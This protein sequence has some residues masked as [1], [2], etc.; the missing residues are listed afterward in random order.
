[1]DLT[2]S[3]RETAVEPPG[4]PPLPRAEPRDLPD[5]PFAGLDGDDA[6]TFDITAHL[7]AGQPMT[8]ELD[9][10][11]RL[12]ESKRADR[13]MP[14]RRDFAFEDLGPW[15]GHLILVDVL[16][17]GRD[18]AFRIFGTRIAEFLGQDLT[19]KRL[20]MLSP[21]VQRA[22]GEEYGEVVATRRPRYI[23]GSPHL[24]RR[25]SVAARAIL[26]LSHAGCAVDQLLIGFYEAK[27]RR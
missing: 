9:A 6:L 22:M 4:T 23:V 13:A 7:Q 25:F 27:N 20:N 18:Y 10:L 12:W 11:Y 21:R 5:D 15:L 3:L 26:P 19:G 1:M 14:G 8:P 17:H 24:S 16:D 2:C